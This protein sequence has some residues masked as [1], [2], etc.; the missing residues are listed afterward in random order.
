MKS[1]VFL[2]IIL[3]ILIG[4]KKKDEKIID[5]TIP[6][7]YKKIAKITCTSTE[8]DIYKGDSLMIE[9]TGQN[10]SKVSFGVNTYYLTYNY[11]PNF[12]IVTYYYNQGLV[13][14]IDTL[15]LNWN[16][17]VSHSRL[18]NYY[19]IYNSDGYLI[20]NNDCDMQIV[21]GN[22]IKET[23][24]FDYPDSSKRGCYCEYEFCDTLNSN[25]F[26][27]FSNFSVYY[28]NGAFGK[29]NKKIVKSKTWRNLNGT[30]IYKCN[31][32]YELDSLNI[33]KNIHQ[34]EGIYTDDYKFFYY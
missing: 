13:E 1:A 9:Y 11:F 25:N 16:G 22:R 18:D 4:C 24:K 27:Q 17:L 23:I 7:T 6:I 14:D 8:N 15:D 12:I 5:T 28:F 21:N 10:I 29:P 32:S 2:I 34:T 3:S 19:Y 26:Y 31:Y 20:S 30:L 33:I